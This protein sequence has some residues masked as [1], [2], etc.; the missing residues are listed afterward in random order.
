M[1]CA[2]RPA[3]GRA[4]QH[5]TNV[6]SAK[7]SPDG[8]RIVTASDDGTAQVWDAQTGRRLTE[9]LSTAPTWSPPNSAPT[10]SAL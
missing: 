6:V 1:G 2:D 10:V 8:R 9:P 7:F 5:G 3:T 4:M